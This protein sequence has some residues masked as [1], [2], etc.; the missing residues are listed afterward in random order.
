MAMES[1]ARRYARAVF[2]L[3]LE[4]GESLDA[5]LDDIK[6][7]QSV[8]EDPEVF[9]VLT[10]PS[11][12]FEHKREMIDRALGGLD[13]LRRNLVYLLV[14]GGR[15]DAIGALARELARLVNEHRGIAEA[16]IT[17]AVP[18]SDEESRAI[19][20]R[21]GRVLD[22]TVVVQRA[23]DPAI[24]GGIVVRVGDTLING[25]V[26]GRLEALREQLV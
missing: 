19:G 23:V 12:A 10:A 1:V 21:L 16:T 11:L 26:A 25:S 20:E 18:I 8:L 13:P 3:A 17:T 5:W 9:A 2:E 4:R 6:T 14:E 7:L 15:V 22:R 24:L